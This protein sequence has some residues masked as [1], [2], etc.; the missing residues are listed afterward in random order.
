MIIINPPRLTLAALVVCAVFAA[1]SARAESPDGWVATGAEQLVF[2]AP[3]DDGRPVAVFSRPATKKGVN[4]VLIRV[5]LSGFRDKNLALCEDEVPE[6]TH[7]FDKKRSWWVSFRDGVLKSLKRVLKDLV[8]DLEGLIKRQLK[9]EVLALLGVAGSVEE[10]AVVGMGDLLPSAAA[11]LALETRA[12][13]V[14]AASREGGDLATRFVRANG[15]TVRNVSNSSR[16]AV[17]RAI[18]SALM[19]SGA[20]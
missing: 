3:R 19:N 1:P 8:K 10:K 17:V 9:K 12:D 6:L 2:Q 13:A 11:A 14:I 20:K 16:G 7:N 4:G 15:T 18:H 5:S